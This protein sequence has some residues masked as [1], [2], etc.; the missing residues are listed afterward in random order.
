M[1][2]T[3][4]CTR[5]S[6]TFK[7]NANIN[8]QNMSTEIHTLNEYSPNQNWYKFTT[9]EYHLSWIVQITQ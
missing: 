5:H 9:L 8:M 6:I 1:R 3:F 4:E 7:F 2:F